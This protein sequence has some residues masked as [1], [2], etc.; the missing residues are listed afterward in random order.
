MKNAKRAS[1]ATILVTTFLIATSA[2]ADDC[3]GSGGSGGSDPPPACPQGCFQSTCGCVP[4]TCSEF[5]GAG[6]NCLMLPREQCK[7]CE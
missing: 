7:R 2:S 4:D 5:A 1:I 6:F 3:T